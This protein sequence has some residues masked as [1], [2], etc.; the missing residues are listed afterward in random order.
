MENYLNY[1]FAP[2]G[3]QCPICKRVYS[4]STPMCYSCGNY[5]TT[6][7]TCTGKTESNKTYTFDLDEFMKMFTRSEDE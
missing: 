7:T 4:P 5:E 1:G 3:W 2:Q 6:T